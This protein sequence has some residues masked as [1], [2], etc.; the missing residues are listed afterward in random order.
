M[1]EEE[2]S[3]ATKLVEE[4]LSWYESRK[5]DATVLHTEYDEKLKDLESKLN[6][7]L[8]KLKQFLNIES[9][10]EAKLQLLFKKSERKDQGDMSKTSYSFYIQVKERGSKSK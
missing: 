2:Y 9:S 8:S 6:P 7:V 5:A 1:T 4:S 3:E 10:K